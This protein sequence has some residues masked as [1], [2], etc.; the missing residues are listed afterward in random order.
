MWST[1]FIPDEEGQAAQPPA[2]GPAPLGA[3]MPARHGKRRRR[4]G[5]HGPPLEDALEGKIKLAFFVA[6]VGV[7]LTVL[8]VGTEF[9]AELSPPK[10]FYNNETCVLAHYGLWRGCTKTLLVADV[11]P[12]RDSCGPPQLPGVSNCSYFKFFTTG[13]N[14]L[15]FQKTPQKSKDSVTKKSDTSCSLSSSDLITEKCDVITSFC[16]NV[17]AAMLALLSLVLMLLGS[18]C[19]VM[20]IN[21][22]LLSFLKPASCCFSLAGLLVLISLLIFHWSVEALLVSDRSVPL[23]RRL[24][25]SVGVLGVAGA[26]LLGGGLLFLLLALP[27]RPW[28]CCPPPHPGDH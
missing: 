27:R 14:A 10:K 7:V 24:S 3:L 5:P 15:M 20:A 17:A 18:V 6:I 8:G 2:R 9:W 26:F 19:V 21:K 25:W 23:E 12:D 28:Q 16:L 22:Q 13:E 1:I 4:A 11:P